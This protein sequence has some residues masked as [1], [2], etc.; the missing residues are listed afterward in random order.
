M[1]SYNETLHK[2]RACVDVNYNAK[3]IENEQVQEEQ[4]G[5]IVQRIKP[6]IKDPIEM[7]SEYK[8]ADFK[9]E[10]IIASGSTDL[11]KESRLLSNKM[12]DDENKINE[13]TEKIENYVESKS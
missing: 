3:Y 5:V 1:E 11:L 10:N 9:L 13:L 6:I 12:A 7:N 8:V 4:N 2:K